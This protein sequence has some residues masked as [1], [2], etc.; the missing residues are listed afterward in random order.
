MYR[1]GIVEIGEKD[2]VLKAP[3]DPYTVVMPQRSEAMLDFLPDERSISIPGV[4]HAAYVEAPDVFN[5]IVGQF[6][7]GHAR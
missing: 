1:G 7:R 3:R 5:R 4:G 6:L 2:A